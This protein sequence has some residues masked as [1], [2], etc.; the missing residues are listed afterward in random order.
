MVCL[1]D[2]SDKIGYNKLISKSLLYSSNG[3][4]KYFGLK[5]APLSTSKS[6][7]L[8]SRLFPIA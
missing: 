8:G 3:S 5:I 1:S 4:N 6:I 2:T 7:I